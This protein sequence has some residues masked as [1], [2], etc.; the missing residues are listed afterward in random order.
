MRRLGTLSLPCRGWRS[1]RRRIDADSRRGPCAFGWRAGPFSCV[2]AI[3]PNELYI[4]L[5]GRF[6][7][8]LDGRP[9]MIAE[10]GPGEPIGELAFFGSGTRTANVVAARDSDVLML[11]RDAYAEVMRQAPGILAGIL[12]SVASRLAAVTPASPVLRGRPARTVAILPIGSSGAAHRL[13][14]AAV[15]ARFAP[16][17]VVVVS[18]ETMPAFEAKDEAAI[19]DFL[20]AVE[21]TADIVLLAIEPERTRK[22]SACVSTAPTISCWS[23]RAWRAAPDVEPTQIER[24]GHGSLHRGAPHADRLPERRTSRSPAPSDGWPAAT[25]RSTTMSRST[26]RLTSTASRDF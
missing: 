12:T 5:A 11:T 4:V 2:R 25:S 13:H 24:R 3:L 9:G 8:T 16:R 7:V 1:C 14:R 20:I 19:G 23:R 26:A 18:R 22:L 6:V 17:S 21:K 15:R 10:I